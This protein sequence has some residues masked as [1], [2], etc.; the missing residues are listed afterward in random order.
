MNEIFTRILDALHGADFWIALLFLT[1][2][3]ICWRWIGTGTKERP[4]F[5]RQISVAFV[6]AIL[7][8]AA[9]WVN[10]AVFQ[11]ERVS[12]KNLTRILVMRIVGRLGS[13]PK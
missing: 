12:S 10:H 3:I 2:G 5:H 6:L 4:G 1:A 8:G 9:M 13:N 7:A 11:R